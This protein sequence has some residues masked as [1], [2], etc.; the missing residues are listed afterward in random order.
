MKVK[1]I[2]NDSVDN[3]KEFKVRRMNYDQVVVNYPGRKGIEIFKI[4][5]VEFI[6]E[7]ELDEFLIE[8]RYL[9]KIKIN[10]G[11]SVIFYKYLF[12]ELEK[13][14]EDKIE[15]LKVLR[16]SFKLIN[17]RGFW[18][19]EIIIVLNND[20]GAQV[21]VSG[22]N[23]KKD[24]YNYDV[25]ELEENELKEFCEFSIKRLKKEIKSKNNQLNIF[26]EIM[27]K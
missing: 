2:N 14:K 12:D 21:N 19:K 17:K 1:I 23:F 11:I 13:L 18:E 6:S 25:K 9:L 16:D 22:Q 27:N 15:D 24:S 26:L 3:G 7:T 10:R 20:Y 5:D 4:S 8:H